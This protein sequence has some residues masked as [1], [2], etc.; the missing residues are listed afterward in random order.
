MQLMIECLVLNADITISL[1]IN[2]N[3]CC[4]E[5]TRNQG[6]FI[7]QMIVPNEIV[8]LAFYILRN[9]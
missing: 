3:L 8:I 5:E 7:F 4:R 6:N 2:D 9:L 1:M